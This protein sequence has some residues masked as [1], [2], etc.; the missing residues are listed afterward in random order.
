MTPRHPSLGHPSGYWVYTDSQ[1]SPFT[2]ICRFDKRDGRGKEYRPFSLQPDGSWQWKG[3]AQPRPL[4]KL[5]RLADNPMLPVIVVEGEKAADALQSVVTDYVVTTAMHGA[6]SSKKTDW[7]PLENRKVIIWPDA[8]EA[9]LKYAFA[10][11]GMLHG[12]AEDLSIIP[13]LFGDNIPAHLRNDDNLYSPVT[14][15]DAADAVDD[16]DLAPVIPPF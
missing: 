14:G 16:G 9:G 5:K 11:E 13:I 3:T 7:S 15:W 1:G 10:I 8:D 6:Q 4:Y 2:S 12:K